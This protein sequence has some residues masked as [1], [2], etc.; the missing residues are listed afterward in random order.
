MKT[1]NIILFYT[2]NNYIKSAFYTTDIEN[3]LYDYCHDLLKLALDD[4][5]EGVEQDVILLEDEG[6]ERTL[7]GA[8]I[9]ITIGID[10][11]T[12]EGKHSYTRCNFKSAE[13]TF[14]N[15]GFIEYSY[16]GDLSQ[17]FG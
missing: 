11:D 12:I 10:Y 2:P 6:G 16:E 5:M 8:N 15:L 14:G 13:I 7:Y 1:G 4:Y 9:E 17:V 3:E